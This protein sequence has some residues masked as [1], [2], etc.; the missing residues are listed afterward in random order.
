MTDSAT[1][2]CCPT[3]NRVLYDRCLAKCG[4]CGSPIP[5]SLRFKPEEISRIKAAHDEAQAHQLHKLVS[6][7]EAAERE[8]LESTNY[9][10][11]LG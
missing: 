6:E 9:P 10:S 2:R 4:F 3:C 7:R 1:A 11:I 8:S 5:E